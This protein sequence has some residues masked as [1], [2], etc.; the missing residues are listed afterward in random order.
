MSTSYIP[1]ALR[2]L[3]ATR[4]NQ[5]CEYCLM[6]ED[7]TYFGCQV[8]HVISEKHGG[9]TNPENTAYACSFCNRSKG[10]DIGSL[11]W[12]TNQ[13]VRFYNPRIDR[14]SDHFR[15]NGITILALTEIG[16]VTVKIL[17]LNHIDRL[18][19]REELQRQ[20]LYPPQA[21]LHLL[22]RL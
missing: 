15:L 18:F 8:D 11:I 2:R 5:L 22:D 4:A 14:W 20:G 13:F 17:D 19:E 21:A 10:S 3:V 7:D 12:R 6:H 16:E 9:P 1:L